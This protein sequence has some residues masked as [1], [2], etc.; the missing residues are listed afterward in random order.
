[1][2]KS[3]RDFFNPTL[4]RLTSWAA[5]RTPKRPGGSSS[6]IVKVSSYII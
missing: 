5:S 6:S 1:M 3:K 4:D 2:G